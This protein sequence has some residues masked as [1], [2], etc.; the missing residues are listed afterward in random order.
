MQGTAARLAFSAIL[1]AC[2]FQ[3]AAPGSGD[4]GVD[5]P[6]D[7]PPVTCGTLHCDPNALCGSTT[8]ATC[9]CKSG[10]TGDGMTCAD[11]DECATAN[12][13]CAAACQNTIGSFT[14]YAPQSCADLKA[15]GIAADGAYTLYYQAN[16]AQ[17]WTAYCAR[18]ATTP[19]EYVT[20]TTP[21]TG[22]YAAGGASPGTDV[23]STYTRIRIDPSSLKITIGDRS[24]ATSTGKLRHNMST[25]DVIAMPLGVAMD[26]VFNFSSTAT[27]TIDLAGTH[28]ALPSTS[29]YDLGG[30]KASGN[31][32]P[33]GTQKFTIHGGGSCGWLAPTGTPF[34]PFNDAANDAQLQLSYKP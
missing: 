10:F 5:A 28:F 12:G 23:T 33:T 29:A 14:C 22:Q 24:F 31:V 16:A 15:H 1:A 3:A 8:V 11:V 13:G 17:P 18:M 30:N 27:A 32:V 26:C 21:A 2:G 6:I 7:A 19:A 20:P 4:A 9:I 34:N 25:T